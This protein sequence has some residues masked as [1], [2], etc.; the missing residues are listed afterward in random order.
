MDLSR[1]FIG[2][3]RVEIALTAPQETVKGEMLAVQ[4]LWHK[5]D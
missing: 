2:Y 3:L 5:S 1:S 4:N